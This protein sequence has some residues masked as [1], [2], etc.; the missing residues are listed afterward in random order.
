V[1]RAC[2]AAGLWD[3]ATK[4]ASPIPAVVAAWGI[5]CREL[6][7]PVCCWPPPRRAAGA[8]RPAAPD[9]GGA[10]PGASPCTSWPAGRNWRAWGRP[11]HHRLG[12]RGRR[13]SDLELLLSESAIAARWI[14]CAFATEASFS[15][16]A[17]RPPSRLRAW[18]CQGGGGC[19]RAA[20]LW[21]TERPPAQRPSA[22]G[23]WIWPANSCRAC[24]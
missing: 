19:R 17:E 2:R 24:S 22:E 18:L 15:V 11:G 3:Q 13:S 6:A 5:R 12:W 4:P 16:A 21:E 9:G 10:W 14:P 1:E 8:A 7:P 20:L 23:L